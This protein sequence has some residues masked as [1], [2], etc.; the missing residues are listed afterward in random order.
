MRTIVTRQAETADEKSRVYSLRYDYY[1][2]ARELDIA[3]DHATRS[4]A[5]QRDATA[6]QYAT[7]AGDDLV[8]CFRAEIGSSD[9]LCFAADWSFDDF[10]ET[11]PDQIAIISSLCTMPYLRDAARIRAHMVRESVAIAKEFDLPHVFFETAP[12]L[13]PDFHAAGLSRKGMTLA[14]PRT[15]LQTA[16][17]LLDCR[18]RVRF[19]AAPPIWS[20]S[21]ETELLQ[22]VPASRRPRLAI[23]GGRG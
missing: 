21:Q 10:L 15:G 20:Q 7:F 8:G 11:P 3:A 17:Y 19:P 14:D 2:V 16:V 12:N 1:V 23:V 6:L 22:D 9:E 4:L 18:A 5:D 13:W